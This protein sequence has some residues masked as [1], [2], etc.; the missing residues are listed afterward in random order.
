MANPTTMVIA[1]SQHCV[2][3]RDAFT[4]AACL[5]TAGGPAGCQAAGPFWGLCQF[6]EVRYMWPALGLG[7]P[8]KRGGIM[9]QPGVCL[10]QVQS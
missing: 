8:S 5:Q 6:S 3:G 1:F 2:Q 10:L 9:T 4:E 7:G